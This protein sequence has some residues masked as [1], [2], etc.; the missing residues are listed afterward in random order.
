[1]LIFISIIIFSTVFYPNLTDE[2]K[3]LAMFIFSIG[4]S[5]FGYLGVRKNAKDTFKIAVM[6]C[7]IGCIFVSLL[8]TRIYFEMLSDSALLI[9]VLLWAALVC[10]LSKFSNALFIIIGQIGIIVTLLTSITNLKLKYSDINIKYDQLLEGNVIYA[11][12]IAFILGEI[13]MYFS[14]KK[15]KTSVLANHTGL[16]WGVFL[17][18]INFNR[19]SLKYFNMIGSEYEITSLIDIIVIICALVYIMRNKDE[20]LYDINSIFVSIFGFILSICILSFVSYNTNSRENQTGCIICSI[21]LLALLMIY[22]FNYTKDRTTHRI[23]V[24]FLSI[25]LLFDIGVVNEMWTIALTFI[26]ILAFEYMGFARKDK[27]FQWMAVWSPFAY[28]LN[29][30]SYPGL[31][32]LFIMLITFT[33][34]YLMYRFKQKHTYSTF[35]KIVLYIEFLFFFAILFEAFG[36]KIEI[37][38]EYLSLIKYIIVSL[39]SVFAMKTDYSK[40]FIDGSEEMDFKVTTYIINGIIMISGLTH[41]MRY[42]YNPMVHFMYILVVLTLYSVNSVPLF[43]EYESRLVHHKSCLLEST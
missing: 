2:I 11:L 7:G 41:I 10:Y 6:A 4:I 1:L 37:S 17:L 40:S 19:L 20:S 28:V 35:Y 26:F 30:E 38:R 42:N 29:M 3:V 5:V 21:I 15:N 23:T 36:K 13:M 24:L 34:P 33:I 8:V 9:L 39:A 43:D 31:T 12:F 32:L 27:A 18:F 25:I 14:G 22:A 16:A